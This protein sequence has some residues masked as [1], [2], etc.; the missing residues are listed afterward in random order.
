M[1][2]FKIIM[3]RQCLDLFRSW[4]ITCEILFLLLL[5][6]LFV[7]VAA[8]EN[9]L[10]SET[11]VFFTL[12]L[13]VPSQ[14]LKIFILFSKLFSFNFISQYKWLYVYTSSQ[15][16]F[17]FACLL[18]YVIVGCFI[19][20]ISYFL[21]AWLLTI[22]ANNDFAL[23]QSMSFIIFIF[24]IQLLWISMFSLTNS[25]FHK[26]RNYSLLLAAIIFIAFMFLLFSFLKNLRLIFMD[27]LSGFLI[28]SSLMLSVNELFLISFFILLFISIIFLFSFI[29][30]QKNL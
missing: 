8:I 7:F 19:P 2:T 17:F 29:N 24:S 25:I 16:I 10:A 18:S 6:F 12:Y 13:Y 1:K 14:I 30:T 20:I 15:S 21:F 11:F 26:E 28:G 22:F 4:I 9:E 3:Q 23:L 5:F 27:S